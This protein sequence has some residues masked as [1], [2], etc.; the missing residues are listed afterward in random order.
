M[1]AEELVEFWQKSASED[2]RVAKDN[3]KLGH[4]HWAL[5]FYQLV[6]EKV[7]K[8]LI[9]KRKDKNPLP[10]HN[11]VK[12]SEEAGINYRAASWRGILE[13]VQ[14]SLFL[15][16]LHSSS[17]LEGIRR[18]EIKLSLR[19]KQ[20]FKEITTFNIEARY[21]DIKLSF[22]KKATRKYCAK[23]SKKCEEYYLWLK[24]K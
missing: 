17:L 8:S 11:L 13:R 22:Y 23:W 5:F 7:L 2:L 9:V 10:T 1:T 19:Q 18:V 20:D 21:D 24:E 15:C 12:L 6:I 14:K 16:R 3:L 4:F